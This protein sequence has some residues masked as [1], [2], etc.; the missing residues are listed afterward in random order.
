MDPIAG[1]IASGQ[2]APLADLAG[3]GDRG[4]GLPDWARPPVEAILHVIPAARR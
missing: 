1:A 3:T 2:S 4:I